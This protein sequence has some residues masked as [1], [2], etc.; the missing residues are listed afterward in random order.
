MS[1]A[2]LKRNLY[3]VV[4]TIYYTKLGGPQA[5]PTVNMWTTLEG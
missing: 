1:A 5:R 3:V 2:H 4:D